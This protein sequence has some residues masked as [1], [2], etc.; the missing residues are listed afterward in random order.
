MKIELTSQELQAL[1]QALSYAVMNAPTEQ[2]T[3]EYAMLK[4]KIE[5]EIIRLNVPDNQRK[6]TPLKLNR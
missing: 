1:G 5:G 4:V 6:S 2:E 3:A